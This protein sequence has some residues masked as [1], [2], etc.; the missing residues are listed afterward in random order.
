LFVGQEVTL[1]ALVT[2]TSTTMMAIDQSVRWSASS[3]NATGVVRGVSP[4]ITVIT[5]ASVPDATKQG[6]ATITILP[7]TP[8]V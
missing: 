2:G 4:G 3:G 8:G 1:V 7:P 6:T 5:A